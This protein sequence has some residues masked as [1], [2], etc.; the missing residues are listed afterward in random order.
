MDSQDSQFLEMQDQVRKQKAETEELKKKEMQHIS[1]LASQQPAMRTAQRPS[2]AS[3]SQLQ[4]NGSH[5]G[6]SGNLKREPRWN[7]GQHGIGDKS[8]DQSAI[9]GREGKEFF[10]SISRSKTPGGDGSSGRNDQGSS[11]Q[12]QGPRQRAGDESS[13]SRPKN[14]N[15]SKGTLMAEQVEKARQTEHLRD[16]I[17]P[18]RGKSE[19]AAFNPEAGLGK[20]VILLDNTMQAKSWNPALGNAAAQQ[21]RLNTSESSRFAKNNPNNSSVPVFQQNPKAG[22]AKAS[23]TSTILKNKRE[24]DRQALLASGDLSSQDA[25]LETRDLINEIIKDHNFQFNSVV[26]QVQSINF[27][28]GMLTAKLTILNKE[29][30]AAHLPVNSGQT[31]VGMFRS[32]SETK[33]VLGKFK[34]HRLSVFDP[35]F[36]VCARSGK[37]YLLIKFF[38]LVRADG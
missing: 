34:T 17:A 35:D 10:A 30:R 3:S 29:A 7:P 31:V 13:K 25:N 20:K 24:M 2:V 36:F 15:P 4:K 23:N 8:S 38:R 19:G 22:Q 21:N 32:G 14:M 1:Q 6:S 11:G 16:F 28:F 12:Q 9:T 5:S 18:P 33:N 26:T 27:V 37:S